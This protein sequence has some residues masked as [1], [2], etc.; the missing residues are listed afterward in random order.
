MTAREINVLFDRV[1]QPD[2]FLHQRHVQLMKVT[3]KSTD[4]LRNGRITSFRDE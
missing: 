2:G 4:L 3:E 1:E